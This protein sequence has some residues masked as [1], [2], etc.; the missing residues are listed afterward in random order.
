MK[1]DDLFLA[2]GIKVDSKGL[3]D[4]QTKLD[5]FSETA[6]KLDAT[7]KSLSK[8]KVN[9]G[10]TPNSTGSARA[11][12]STGKGTGAISSRQAE[13]SEAAELKSRQTEYYRGLKKEASQKK[14]DERD[15]ANFLKDDRK[16]EQAALKERTKERKKEDGE[17]K[18]FF[19]TVQDGY[20]GVRD[21]VLGIFSATG[22]TKA[23]N[24][25]MGV[26]DNAKGVQ[27]LNTQYDLD[28]IDTQRWSNIFQQ[29]SKGQLEK[30]E[31]LGNIQAI[32]ARLKAAQTN[33]DSELRGLLAQAGA[34]P[35]VTNPFKLFE[36]LRESGAVFNDPSVF[37]SLV[38]ALGMNPSMAAA[39]NPAK[40]P[41]AEFKKY[42]QMPVASKDIIDSLAYLSQKKAEVSNAVDVFF[43]QI[44]SVLADLTK[45][46]EKKL[47]TPEGKKE[48]KEK[49]V[50][51]GAAAAAA[52]PFV[53]PVL[54][55]VL[56]A[57]PYAGAAYVAYDLGSSLLE[58]AKGKDKEP[59]KRS[60]GVKRFWEIQKEIE[61]ATPAWLAVQEANIEAKSAG[62]PPLMS[63][64]KDVPQ[65]GAVQEYLKLR[66]PKERG[67]FIK[68]ILENEE[69]TNIV[70]ST[71]MT[72]MGAAPATYNVNTTINAKEMDKQTIDYSA[73]K[74]GSSVKDAQL[75]NSRTYATFNTSGY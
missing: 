10:S 45:D 54:K 5:K 39:L 23:Y 72:N 59:K 21:V 18:K 47:E 66:T 57:V 42:A 4:A 52:L 32:T 61:A 6:E 55:T 27:A 26:V 2:L 67:L 9:L 51:Y 22:I 24:S 25:V 7:L 28:V 30:P 41:D 8:N 50:F 46:I 70:R 75:K 1:L 3:D 20:K 56:R 63:M 74:I 69:K 37:T 68:Q 35:S 36:Q 73:N 49:G 16:I 31:I 13:K 60:T 14:Q 12:T 58:N 29:A 53:K 38:N 65:I 34:D 71:P 64:P 43:K 15:R 62:L 17:N 48:L 40:T 44:I 11:F 19:R 33:P